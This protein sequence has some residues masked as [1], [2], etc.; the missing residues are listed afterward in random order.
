MK[1]TMILLVTLALITGCAGVD[2]ILR[3]PSRGTVDAKPAKHGPPPHAPAHGYRHKHQHG[4][5]LE[6]DTGIGAYVVV[7]LPDTYFF[8]GLYVRISSD[9]RW[10]VAPHLDNPWRVAVEGEVPLKLKKKKAKKNPG[11]GKKSGKGKGK[12]W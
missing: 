10:T 4:V 5:Q 11:K 6:F 1:N 12:K 3:F 2:T 9:G 8:N 7:D